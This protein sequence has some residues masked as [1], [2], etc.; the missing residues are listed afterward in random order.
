MRAG[1]LA[2]LLISVRGVQLKARGTRAHA[3]LVKS[4]GRCLRARASRCCAPSEEA[5][6]RRFASSHLAAFAWA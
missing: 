3:V 1:A 2:T 4:G 6:G 5:Q